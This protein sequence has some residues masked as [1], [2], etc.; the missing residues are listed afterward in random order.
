MVVNTVVTPSIDISASANPV[1][2]GTNVTFTATAV[3][4]GAT[5][6]YQ[7]KL[8]GNNTGTNNSIFTSAALVNGDVV[9]CVM[10]GA[11][12]A[13]W[14]T[15][16]IVSN[17][18]TMIVNSTVIPSIN[19][20][21]SS[22]NICSGIP[23]TFTATI[24]NGGIAPFY[25]WKINGISAGINSLTFTTSTLMNGDIV[26]CELT[27]SALCTTV[28]TI[29]SNSIVMTVSNSAPASIT[30]NSTHA[31]CEGETVTF[32]ATVVG[33]GT[34]PVYQW[35]VNGIHAGTNTTTYSNNNFSN[36]DQV[37]CTLTPGN[38]AC[39]NVAVNSNTISTTIYALPL[40]NII[41]TDTIVNAGS[42]LHLHAI[43]PAG[44]NSYEW[45][46]AGD[47]SN[48]SSLSPITHPI[49]DSA[50]FIFNAVTNEGCA[51]S[52][53]IRIR[54]YKKLFLP[55]AFT[56]NNDGLNDVFRI[57]PDINF[58]LDELSIYNRWGTQVF[59]TNDIN[60]GWNGKYKGQDCEAGTYIYNIQGSDQKGRV[61]LK[62]I[63]VLI[64]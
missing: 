2:P 44:V 28:S 52:K 32:T 29:V 25:Q 13:C 63:I 50:H 51:V 37:V 19:I 10:T 27:S 46:P 39:S 58:A 24:L 26:T 30:I 47:L 62:G 38:S 6:S 31:V 1:C 15:T 61:S 49:N 56:P 21:A 22:N 16:N 34:N 23:V 35:Q 64:R 20:N 45:L 17:N 36:G 55:N 54:I 14:P 57:P 60:K 5:P 41:P 11:G 33:A 12:A 4:G 43:V 48:S 42:Q 8:N 18:I 9:S 40:V 3:N 53:K 7:W 59:S